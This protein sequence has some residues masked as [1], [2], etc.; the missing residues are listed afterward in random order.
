M[1]KPKIGF[2]GLGLMGSAMV[3]RLQ[4]KGYDLPDYPEEPANEQQTDIRARY[5]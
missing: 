5:D 4:D 3:G 1:S 2:I